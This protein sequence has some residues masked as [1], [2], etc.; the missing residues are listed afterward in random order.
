MTLL[1][2]P[3]V[4][5]RRG[6]SGATYQL[7]VEVHWDGR[8]GV[9][10]GFS[11]P[12]MMAGG[13]ASSPSATTSSWHLTDASLESRATGC[14]TPHWSGRASRAAHCAQRLYERAGFKVLGTGRNTLRDD[15]RAVVEYLLAVCLGR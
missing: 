2:K 10:C 12:S 14:L 8:P 9:P 7:K 4:A 13:K 15:G 6:V 5:E 11:A 3:E 1:G